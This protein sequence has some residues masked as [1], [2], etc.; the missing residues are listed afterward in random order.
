RMTS[1]NPELGGHD[2]TLNLP[3]NAMRGAWSLAVH[4]DPEQPPLAQVT[5]LVEDFIPDRIEFDLTAGVDA[6]SAGET[7]PVAVDGR[8]LYGAPAAGLAMEGTL[9]ILPVRQWQG[10]PGYQF[11]LDDE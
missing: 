4:A 6:A 7:F 5:F 3:E 10:M 8:F 1:A 11:G 2:L 9:E